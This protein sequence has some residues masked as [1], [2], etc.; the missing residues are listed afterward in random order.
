MALRAVTEHPKFA[1]LKQLLGLSKCPTL[2]YLEGLW[3]FAGKYTPHGDLGKYGDA[4]IEAWLEWDGPAGKLME[5]FR[6]AGWIDTSDKH[7]LVIHDW[8]LHADNATKLSVK[9]SGR[10][11]VTKTDT[12]CAHRGDI[13]EES[14]TPLRLPEPGAGAVPEPVPEPVAIDGVDPSMVA[15]GVLTELGISGSELFRNISDVCK[16][17]MQS[18]ASPSLLRETMVASYREF[19]KEKAAGHFAFAPGLP[20]FFGER[21]WQDKN[22]WPWKEGFAPPPPKPKRKYHDPLAAD[23]AA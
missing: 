20:K 12:V 2:G 10:D 21:L 8:H 7:R 23:G 16:S 4:E 15:H 19:E 1:R 22:L 3:H 5:S 17:A 18:G 6:T 14:V 13:V 9:R 11:F